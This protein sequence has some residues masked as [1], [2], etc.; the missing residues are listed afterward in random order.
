[1]IRIAIVFTIALALTACGASEAPLQDVDKAAALFFER[2]KTADYDVIYKDASA[3][4]KKNVPEA[5][6]LD[7]LKQIGAI[8]RIQNYSRLRFPIESSGSQR[9][10]SP[11]Y[12]VIFDQ[13]VTE[14]TINFIDEGGE[15]KL[16]GFAVKQ[17]RP[18]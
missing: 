1:M 7:N 14:I 8:G 11:V 18:G 12:S 10:V 17:R 3:E 2:V 6:I 4:F 15:W 9:R 13:A 16:L 5:T